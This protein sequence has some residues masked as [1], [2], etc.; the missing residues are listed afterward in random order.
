MK[1]FKFGGASV[2][3]A[4]AV[5]NVAEII[6]T[7]HED[8]IAIVVSAMGKTTNAFEKLLRAFYLKEGNAAE[9]LE[10]IKAFHFQIMERMGNIISF[11][12]KYIELSIIYIF[13]IY[14]FLL[15]EYYNL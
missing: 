11:Y 8:R 10:Q 2:K 9:E 6:K 1:V 13:I 12:F 4:E 15:T 5:K 3:D 7:Y 14:I